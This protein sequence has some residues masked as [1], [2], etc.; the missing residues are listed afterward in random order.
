MVHTATRAPEQCEPDLV[1]QG[2]HLLAY[3]RLR[4]EKPGRGTAEAKLVAH[5]ECISELTIVHGT[6]PPSDD[7]Y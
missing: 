5:H 6:L 2:R 3:G 1:L 4:D 7:C